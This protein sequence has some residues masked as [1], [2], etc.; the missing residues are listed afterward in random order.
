MCGIAGFISKSPG[1]RDRAQTILEQMC[2]SIAHRGPDASGYWMSDEASVCFGHRRLSIIDLSEAGAQPMRSPSG[3]YELT[4]NGEIYGFQSLRDRLLDQGAVFR[5][6]SDTEVLLHLVEEMGVERTLDQ[7]NGMFAFA[8]FDKQTRRVYFVRDRL[9]KKPLYITATNRSL[10]FGSELKAICAHPDMADAELDRGAISLYLRHNCVPAPYS[11][12]ANTMKLMPGQFL[13]VDIDNLPTSI[14]QLRQQAQPFWDASTVTKNARLERLTDE[15]E[16]LD[17]LDSILR[18]AVAERIVSDVP[19]GAFLSGGIDSTL[20]AALMREVSEEP[21]RTFTIGFNESKFDESKH[22]AVIANHLG[23][24]HTELTASP[25]MA[26]SLIDSMPYVYDEPFAD[27]SQVPTFLLSKLTREHLTVALSGD[28]GDECFGG[29]ARYQRML[30]MNE[31]SNKVPS[32]AMD[33]LGR[34]PTFMLDAAIRV[35]RGAIP[36]TYREEIS[37]DR[38]KKLAHILKQDGFV[39]RY[40]GFLS[41]WSKPEQLVLGTEEPQ[42]RMQTEAIPSDV[43]PLEHMM[44]IDLVTYLTDDVLVKVDRA[45]MATS[46]EVRSPLLDYRVVEEAWRAPR[47]LCLNGGTG[48]VALRRLLARRVPVELFDRPKQGFSVPL[49]EWLRGPLKEW[50]ADTLSPDRIAGQ[51]LLMPKLVTQRWQEHQ[52]GE[53]NWGAH[54]WNILM[55]QAWHDCWHSDQS[56]TKAA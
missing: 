52:S 42:T 16:S 30:A 9:G 47:S 36:K 23:T 11:I 5:G 27:P 48:K 39:D 24:E 40:R 29:Y 54:L 28:G 31:L 17:R 22:A 25:E 6:F 53:R 26:M 20:I 14:D 1:S 12:Y 18:Q 35:S 8:L 7:I 21:I 4:Y 32:L 33:T 13:S 50:A 46:L 44:C 49:N 55:F 51:G 56:A 2:D 34:L 45:S 10:I 3:R 19:I 37:G 43:S 15:E 38:V 41:Q